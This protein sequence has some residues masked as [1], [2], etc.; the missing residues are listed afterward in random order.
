MS[1][2]KNNTE[3]SYRAA[4]FGPK[5]LN[6]EERSLELVISTETPVDMYDWE[7]GEVVPEVLLA[8]G[9]VMPRTVPL[10]DS[11]SRWGVGDVL[12]SVRNKKIEDGLVAGKAF[13]SSVKE[14]EEAL[15]KYREGHLTDFSAGYRINNRQHVPKGKKSEIAG[16]TWRGPV[17]VVTSWT[18][19]EVSC[20]AI[21]ADAKAKARSEDNPKLQDDDMDEE[22]FEELNK[23][24]NGLVET[25]GTLT[26]SIKPVI[27]QASRTK[28][29]E[30]AEGEIKRMREDD[31]RKKE[32]QVANER[33]RI[34]EINKAAEEMGAALGIDFEEIRIEAV[35]SGISV[36]EANKRFMDRIA[37]AKPTDLTDGIRVGITK[38]ERDK[39][40]EAAEDGILLRAG[41]AIDNVGDKET[42]YQNLTLY[43]IARSRLHAANESTKGMDKM[44]VFE[45]ALSTSDFDNILANV[46][47]KAVLEGFEKADETYSVWA[48]TSGRVSDFKAHEFS[49]ASEAPTLLVI[50]PEGGE[51]YLGSIS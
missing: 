7:R 36:A 40:R 49:R 1:K 20:C 16:R 48:D 39:S 3:L 24:V 43:E 26:D 28:T 46:A 6:E 22:R 21:G 15:T 31:L 34:N 42:E 8:N 4:S 27:E 29:V 38:D 14:G 17:N 19:K 2:K 18:I 5:T 30:D 32:L 35:E 45:R 50:K 11:H 47:N 12:G 13:F 51:Y 23:T 9:A 44:Q 10:L 41:I 33:T 37:T 25:V